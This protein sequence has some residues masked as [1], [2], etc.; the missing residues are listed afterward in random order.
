MLAGLIP[1]ILGP[2]LVCWHCVLAVCHSASVRCRQSFVPRFVL[3]LLMCRLGEALNPGPDNFVLGTFNPS[4]LKGKAPYVVSQLAHGDIWAVT[5]THL[6]DQSMNAFRASMQFAR[7][8]HRYCVPGFPVPAQSNRVFH[9]AW[10]G[11]AVLSKHPT[12]AV[13]TCW[14]EGIYESSRAMISTTLVGAVWVTGATV[15][16]EPESGSYPQQKANNEALL[17]AAASQVCFLHKGPRFVAGDWN[18]AYGTLHAFD[19][20]ENAGFVDL[21]DLALQRWGM[22]VSPTCKEKTRKDFCFVPRELQS[23]L[24]S[25]QVLPDIFPDHAVLQGTFHSLG[26]VP[27]RSIWSSAK[28]FPWPVDWQVEPDAYDKCPGD[29]DAKY[30]SLWKHIEDSAAK[31]LPFSVPA[32][33]RGRA[34]TQQT[35]NVV[36]GTFPPPKRSRAGDIQPHYVA[37]SFRHAQW[38]RQVQRLQ[39]YVR[40]V[41]VHG[42]ASEHAFRVWGA[43]VRAKGFTPDFVTW[44]TECGFHTHGAPTA[45]P[46]NAP[47]WTIAECIFDTVTLAF[48]SFESELHKASRLYSR[49]RREQNPNMIFQDV[50]PY[51]HKGVDVLIRHKVATIQEVRMEDMS[52]VLDAPV[53]FAADKPLLC[54]GQELHVIHHEADCLWVQD[55]RGALLW[56]LRSRSLMLWVRMTNC[57]MRSLL[58]G[59]TCGGATETSPMIGGRLFSTLPANTLFLS[60]LLGLPWMIPP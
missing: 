26:H 43:I 11:V 13:N 33:A 54:H 15:Y 12:R 7:S 52:I 60:S 23:L 21:Q 40:Y 4:G 42:A 35:R 19:M 57:L 49:H 5:E 53:N 30:V 28:P 46:Y 22:P 38:L 14:P 41:K 32:A 48:R 47:E 9:S 6:S 25:V 20:L 8:A 51:V 18:V 31:A 55:V 17:H 39:S 29:C 10:R 37:A 45:V 2:I 58:H 1:Q 36:D 3:M 34:A 56:G 24:I 59:V 50:R 16:G 44:W 27:P